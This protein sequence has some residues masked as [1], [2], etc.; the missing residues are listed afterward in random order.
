MFRYLGSI[1]KERKMIQIPDVDLE[2]TT[3]LPKYLILDEIAESTMLLH[4][5]DMF[6]ETIKQRYKLLYLVKIED[7]WQA[8]FIKRINPIKELKNARKSRSTEV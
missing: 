4:M 5:E 7:K 2:T 8:R 6:C 1:G 3:E